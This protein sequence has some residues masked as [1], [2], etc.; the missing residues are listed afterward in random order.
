MGKPQEY[1]TIASN[2]KA[3]YRFHVNRKDGLFALEILAP[4]VLGEVD[5]DF[6]VLPGYGSNQLLF[7]T[8][9]KLAGPDLQRDAVAAATLEKLAPDAAHLATGG[10]VLV[11]DRLGL[12]FDALEGRVETVLACLQLRCVGALAF[13]LDSQPFLPISWSERI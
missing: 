6:P 9:N 10:D 5:G 2:R 7:K 13:C 11:V 8:R 4:V 1:R 12:V 3:L